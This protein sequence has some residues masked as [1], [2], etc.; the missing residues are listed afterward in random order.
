[1]QLQDVSHYHLQFTLKMFVRLEAA[2]GLILNT[3]YDFESDAV[4]TLQARC[5]VYTVGPLFLPTGGGQ[6]T[7]Q[8]QA[9]FVHSEDD[10]CLTW[11]DAQAPASVLYVSFGTLSTLDGEQMKELA[12]GLED[13]QQPFLWVIRK[14]AISG[15]LSDV[16]PKGFLQRTKDRCLIISWAPQLHVLKHPS[17]GGFLSHCGWNS[18]LENIALKGLPMLCWPDK[19]EQGMNARLL[20]DVW[21][22][23]LEFKAGSDGRVIRGEVEEVVRTLMQ[24]EEGQEMRKRGAELKKQVEKLVSQGGSS[25]A[26]LEALVKTMMNSTISQ[27][28]HDGDEHL[29]SP[30]S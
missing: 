22:L 7:L 28:T 23:G 24:G 3:F 10:G 20:V 19:A 9:G 18:I 14:N 2:V 5:P 21:K 25:F 8:Q 16:L 11:L 1:M 26:N 27:G 17:V 13:S 4:N 15:A 6:E 12:L 29:R 30:L